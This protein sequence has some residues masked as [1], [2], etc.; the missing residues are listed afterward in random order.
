MNVV[1]NSGIGEIAVKGKNPRDFVLVCPIN[2]LAKQ[3]C[4]ILEY[5][6]G[7]IALF[8]LFKASKLQRIKLT[9]FTH[10]ICNQIIVGKFVALFGM[11]PII[12]PILNE[13]AT[14][15]VP[16]AKNNR[17]VGISAAN[18]DRPREEE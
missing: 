13:P 15:I 3:L 14:V 1:E 12:P 16:V 17:G 4:V 2:Q 5:F 9:A 8:P 6:P 7:G 10:I 11:I 18:I